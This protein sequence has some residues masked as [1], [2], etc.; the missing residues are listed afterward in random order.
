MYFHLETL[1][2]NDNTS[3]NIKG[4]RI[5]ILR[6]CSPIVQDGVTPVMEIDIRDIQMFFDL[7]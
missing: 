6:S 2:P 4:D 3:Y 7:H 5:I 1:Y